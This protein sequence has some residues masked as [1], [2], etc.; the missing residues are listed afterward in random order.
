MFRPLKK[1]KEESKQTT[2]NYPMVC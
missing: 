1:G 2:V